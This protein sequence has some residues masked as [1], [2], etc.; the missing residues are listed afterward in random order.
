MKTRD[1]TITALLIALTAVATLVVRIPIP[2][3]QGYLNF[4]D[5]MV[6]ISALLFGPLIGLLAGGLGSALADL[7]GGFSQFA[8]YTLVIKGLEGFLVGAISW[9]LAKRPAPTVGNVLT[10]AVAILVGGAAMIGGYYVAEAFIMGLGT[11]AAAAEVPGNIIQVVGGL[12]VAIPASLLLR[13]L[14]TERAR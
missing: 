14:A 11:A 10:A 9:R 2:A 8:P 3:T 12:I 1:L 7:F 13:G 5:S 6:Y 4:G